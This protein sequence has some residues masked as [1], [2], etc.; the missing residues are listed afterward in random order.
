MQFALLGHDE[1]TPELIEAAH[2][3]GHEIGVVW[4]AEPLR[5]RLNQLFPRAIWPSDWMTFLDFPAVDALI[6]A[7]GM[8]DEARAES[9]RRVAQTGGRA[10]VSHPV[11]ASVLVYFELEMICA[12]TKAQL[13]PYCPWRWRA[14]VE[15]LADWIADADESPVGR[16]EQLL[17]ERASAKRD[18][19]SV[20]AAFGR[21]VDLA[22]RLVGD[23]NSLSAM[24]PGWEAGTLGNL[25]VQMT[26]PLGVSVRWSIGPVES[27]AGLRVSIL[28]PDGKATLTLPD[29]GTVGELVIHA[30]GRAEKTPLDDVDAC[31]AALDAFVD[32]ADNCPDWHAAARGMELADSIEISLRK[33]KTI[34]LYNTAPSEQG[35]FKGIMAAAGCFLLC[36]SLGLFVLGLLLARF[37]VPHADKIPLAVAGLLIVFLLLQSLRFAFPRPS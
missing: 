20:N 33:G 34:P 15:Q 1:Q 22:L 30:S 26:G 25:G 4:D 17:I 2:R 29:D 14:G 23:L 13:V 18:A 6:V 11:N 21:D 27:A 36:A 37:G 12:E 5:P 7:R 10:L 19:A 3:A 32:E 9:L 8:D 35:T 24:A 16:C 28:G 31:A